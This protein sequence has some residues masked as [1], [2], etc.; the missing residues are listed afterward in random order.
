MTET[1][2]SR[3]VAYCRVSLNTYIHGSPYSEQSPPPQPH[4]LSPIPI[5]SDH[6]AKLPT[7]P[8]HPKFANYYDPGVLKLYIVIIGYK[9][10]GASGSQS[11]ALVCNKLAFN[12]A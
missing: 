6:P 7:I 5:K 3:S 8:D 1:A 12:V 11:K 9:Y 4:I 2:L 10:I